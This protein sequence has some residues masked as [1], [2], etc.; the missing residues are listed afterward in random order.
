MSTAGK[1]HTTKRDPTKMPKATRKKIAARAGCG[2]VSDNA[3]DAIEDMYKKR[4]ETLVQKLLALA[5]Y[6][7]VKTIKSRHVRKVLEIG[8]GMRGVYPCVAE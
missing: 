2:T 6:Q 5:S 8:T 1:R 4:V 3:V 7:K